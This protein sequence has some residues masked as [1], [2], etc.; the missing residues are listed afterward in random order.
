ML[1]RE[2]TD[3]IAAEERRQLETLCL[4]PSENHVSP[5]VLAASGSCLMNK[6]SEGYPG[7]R[8]YQGNAIVDDIERAGGASRRGRCSASSTRT[9]SRSRARRPTSRST[10]RSWSPATRC[11]AWRWTPAGT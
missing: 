2:V 10:P 7:R 11:W 1:D 9:S 5:A 3:L 6:Y 8:Y 4:I